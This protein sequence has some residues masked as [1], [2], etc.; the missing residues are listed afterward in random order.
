MEQTSLFPCPVLFKSIVI[1]RRKDFDSLFD[2]FTKMRAVSYVVSPDLLL[3]FFDE[4]GYTDVEIVVG[5]S[6][7]TTTSESYRQ[8]LAQKGINIT[9]RLTERM[10]AGFLKIYL[11]ERTIH[12]KLYLLENGSKYRLIQSSA[13]LTETARAASQQINYAWYADLPEEEP[14]LTQVTDDY[15]KHRQRCT[16]FMDDLI[17]LIGKQQDVPRREVIEVWLKGT[18]VEDET[19][20]VVHLLQSIAVDSVSEITPLEI[21]PGGASKVER[22]IVQTLPDGPAARKQSEKILAPLNPVLEGGNLRLPATAFHRYVH[23][24]H[25]VPLLIIQREKRDVRLGI[26]GEVKQ[27]TGS[28]PDKKQVNEALQHIESYFDMV[29]FGETPDPRFA[30]TNM[31]EAL[32]FILSAP[33]AHEYMKLKRRRMGNIDTRGPRYL[34]IYGPSQNGKSTFLRFALKLI[35]GCGIDP[36]NS[37]NFTKKRVQAAAVFG[38]VFPLAFDDVAVMQKAAQLE[39]VLKPYWETWWKDEIPTPQIILTSNTP[40]LKEWAKSRVKRLDFDVHFVSTTKNKEALAAIFRQ[41]NR[42]FSW[43][44]SIYFEELDH[45]DFLTEDELY[46][47]RNVMERIYRHAG[48]PLPDY[49]P[50]E[51]IEQLYDP[52]RRSWQDLIERIKKA[53][54]KYEKDRVLVH[55]TNDMLPHEIKGYEGLLPQS[56]KFQRRGQTLVIENPE[57][58]QKWLFGQPQT[59][60][61]RLMRKVAG[62]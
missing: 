22:M 15:Q 24:R 20:E 50:R 39:E 54:L 29:N 57:V 18:V 23:E 6:L 42:L 5:E 61:R 14:W 35:S 1:A 55:F 41:E 26:N 45:P 38:T 32:L 16:L 36:L 4:R 8:A 30:K 27:L 37:S 46:P 33:F 13:N 34:Y 43:F 10:Q 62:R 2:G 56:I 11:P 17:A 7:S 3:S 9:E 12:S 51:A 52:G 21:T 47:A 28:L 25:G 53:H 58:F 40:S 49:F 48:R 44:S 31:F 60:W 59:V 19:A